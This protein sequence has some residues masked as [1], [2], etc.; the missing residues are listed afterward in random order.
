MKNG[1]YSSKKGL[2]M[3]PLALLLA[4]TLLVGGVVGGTIAWLTAKTNAVT[5][6]FTVGDINITL[7]E[8][9]GLDFHFV[10]GDTLKKDPKVTV[11]ENSEACYLFVKV[12]VSNNEITYK[13]AENK[14]VT[15]PV[16][17]FEIAD[18]W[19]FY[20]EGQNDKTA[21][22]AFMNGTYYYY[23]N[24]AKVA[25]D[26]DETTRG[27]EFNVIKGGTTDAN[28]EVKVS[29]FVTKDMVTN[30]TNNQPAI[31]FDAAAVQSENISDVHTAFAQAVWAD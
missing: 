23:R 19:T 10:P 26:D 21:P 18:G 8:S 9:D 20:N 25:A 11:L 27:T 28:G 3:K 1:K 2:N 15:V 12:T 13:N 31:V 22:T 7:E 17:D 14:D 30:L 4:L 16:I 24:V 29:Q 5:N 6:T